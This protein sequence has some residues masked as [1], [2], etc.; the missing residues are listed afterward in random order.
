MI[1]KEV[2]YCITT[3]RL[4]AKAHALSTVTL[5]N[6]VNKTKHVYG[7][8]YT[9]TV[10]SIKVCARRK[11]RDKCFFFPSTQGWFTRSQV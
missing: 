7:N 6:C 8:E 11:V 5:R 10:R 4:M 1:Q 9:R 2:H 3:L